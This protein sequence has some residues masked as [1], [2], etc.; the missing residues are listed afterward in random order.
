M[1]IIHVLSGL[2]KGGGERVAVELANQA[3]AHGDVVTIV[4][5]W[6]EDS[7]YLQN[8]VHPDITIRFVTGSKRYVYLKVV[9]WIFV[10]RKW[11]C[12]HDVLHCH[13]TFGAFFG[14][15]V[16]ILLKQILRYKQPLII[17]TNHSVGMPVPEF[18]RWLHSR[19][20]LQCDGVAFMATDPYWNNFIQKHP[21]L[22]TA[23]I[24]NGISELVVSHNPE[25]KNKFLHSIGINGNCTFL[26][27]SLSILRPDRQPWIYI[28]IFEEIFK[29]LG[30]KVHFIM[31]GNGA[32]YENMV[33]LIREKGLTK[34]FHMIGMVNEPAKVMSVLDAYVSINVGATTGIS[35]IEAA[36]CNVPVVGIQLIQGYKT[37]ETDWVWSDEKT[38]A[39]AK[40][41]IYLLQN[42]DE[43]IK[44]K[45]IQKDYVNRHFT[46]EAMYN[47]YNN[48]YKGIQDK[49]RSK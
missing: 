48:F 42:E 34:N 21:K 15:I 35:M 22:T 12:S 7:A 8:K 23:I 10:N 1:K 19:M 47:S 41:I 44:L 32:E 38:G 28:P 29:A 33:N 27:G 16:N 30:E 46:S 25:E 14:S 36:M 37:Q 20:C 18:N 6:P 49:R 13:L 3:A 5:G 17:E 39:V 40:K 43:R 2:T 24:P 26:V 9:A 45:S 31:G 4:S 11:I